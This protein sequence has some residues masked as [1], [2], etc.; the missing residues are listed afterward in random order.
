MQPGLL[1]CDA[2]Y[3]VLIVIS[4]VVTILC[5]SN[6]REARKAKGNA[7][8]ELKIFAYKRDAFLKS[9][10]LMMCFE[11]F[12]EIGSIVST[13]LVLFISSN[14]IK[15]GDLS[16]PIHIFLFSA[17]SLISIYVGF[18]VQPKRLSIGYRT[19]SLKM[20]YKVNLALSDPKI[21]EKM[22][23]NKKDKA[24]N[25]FLGETEFVKIVDD[26]K[27]ELSKELNECEKIIAIA[28]NQDWNGNIVDTSLMK[29]IH[30]F[31]VKRNKGEDNVKKEKQPEQSKK[32]QKKD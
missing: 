16:G 32:R 9:T 2:I 7:P 27:K 6:S 23:N 8:D 1:V 15:P 26:Y 28:H 12:L 20:D 21:V 22:K 11:F 18:K 17:I 14:F 31:K 5:C 29:D 13:I 3:G 25:C 4:I 30:D 10:F 24:E 19:A